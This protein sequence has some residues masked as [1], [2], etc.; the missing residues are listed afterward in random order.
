M[1]NPL[2]RRY[3]A[4]VTGAAL[5]AGTLLVVAPATA[6]AADAP[7]TTTTNFK[8]TCKANNSIKQVVKTT[9]SSVTVTAPTKVEPGETFTY[10]IQ[11][12]PSSYPNSDSGA[13]TT[14]IS[15]IKFDFMIPDNATFVSASVAGSGT[16][17]D[18][19]APGVLRIDESGSPSATGKILRLSGNNEVIG[20]APSGKTNTGD[21]GG[22]RAPKLK[23]NLNGTNSSNGDSWFQLP[24]VNVT[25]V[26]GAAG[27]SIQPKVRTGGAAGNFNAFENFN[28]TLPKA[29]LLGTQW[30]NTRCTPR[31]TEGAALNTGAGPLATINV[32]APQVSTT[33]ELSA[34][35]TAET[36][37]AVALTATVAPAGATGSVQFKDN[38]TDIG[39]AVA[40]ANGKATLNHA[41]A[42]AGAHKITAVFTATGNFTGSTSSERTVTVSDPAPV[43]V[44]TTLGLA[45][46]KNAET[47]TP[48]DLTATVTPAN[49]Q[50][51]VQFKDN[52]TDLGTAVAVANGKATLN[53][54][55]GASGAHAITAE[56][57]A[58]PGFTGSTAGAKTVTVSDPAPVDVA[59]TL[60]LS[61]P[62]NAETDA[63]VNLTAAVTPSNAQGAVQF[64]DNGTDIGSPVTVSNG[65]A[66]LQHSF[67]ASGSHN[68][69]AT[70]TGGTGFAGSTASAQTVTVTN[71]QVP[72]AQTATALAAPA[73]AEAGQQVNLSATVAPVP[74][75]GSVQFKIAGSP[76]GAPVAVDG[77]GKAAMPYTFNAA[78]SF[79]VSAEYLGTNGFA[80]STASSRT[81]TV[82]APTPVDVDTSLALQVPATLTA[83][84]S[85]D[86][87]ATVTPS[88]AQGTV[89]FRIGGTPVGAPVTVSG[90]TATLP[91]VFDAAGSYTVTAVFTGGTG[92]TG[93]EAAAQAVTVTDP[94]PVDAATTTL[95]SVPGNAKTGEPEKLYA[96]VYATGTS[97]VLSSVG[98]VE[99]FDGGSS[100]GT[101]PVTD[102]VATLTHTFTVTGTR[103]IT[104]AFSGGTGFTESSAAAKQVQVTAPTVADVQTATVLTVPVT[105]ATG[106][107]VQLSAQVTGVGNAPV[108]GTVQFFDGDKPIGDAITV[109]DGKA[110]LNHAFTAAGTRTIRV[111]FSG[112]QGVADSTSSTQTIQV[113]GSTPG[114]FG[115]LG[116]LLGGL[117]FGS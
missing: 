109:V 113:T 42:A 15:R 114:G 20:N 54:A 49:A 4:P 66:T 45:V 9:D 83:G 100:I 77:S 64:K 3:A 86:L 65:S 21:E 87:R 7:V 8:T 41:F 52:G 97:D 26:A 107:A 39:S 23:K 63:S 82:T 58:G 73:T 29:S 60:G 28:T 88:N 53:H 43:D 91:H 84:T 27:T 35:A 48:V 76:V 59:T 112:G 102:G 32:V 70:F 61:V 37:T 50:G 94:T 14:N 44:A 98:T 80:P 106:A 115:S 78:G 85:G 103:T 47:G 12:G 19:V 18:N 72:D 110:V 104:A 24:A 6:S 16:N 93:S 89:Q 36:G 25:V 108:N 92:F 90:G 40:V 71:P 5:V 96:T 105:A 99:F 2:L 81:V 101:A 62:Q 46:P 34:P 117:N 111:V 1:R 33:T 67:A 79:G 57:I 30:A 51:A 95:L 69:T 68:I 11:L 38:G 10:R 17:L 31:N 75:G 13:T 55:F 22:I 74:T 56:F 116:D